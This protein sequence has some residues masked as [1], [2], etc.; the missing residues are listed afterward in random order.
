MM[1]ANWEESPD[2]SEWEMVVV[3]IQAAFCEGYLA[4]ECDWHNAILTPKEKGD[5]HGI[6][7]VEVFWKTMM[8]IFICHLTA[9]IQFHDTLSG[10]SIVRG[11]GIASLEDNLIQQIMAMK[12]EVLYEIFLDLHKEYDALDRDLCLDILVPYGVGPLALHLFR[13][14]RDILTIVARARG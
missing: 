14:Y 12:E 10:F 1:A 11:T 9:S 8:E 3:L 4:E 5:F 7:L 13:K 2:P 6:R